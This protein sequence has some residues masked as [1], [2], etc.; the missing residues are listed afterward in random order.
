MKPLMLTLKGFRGIRDGLGLDILTLDFERLADGAELIAIAGANGRGKTT[1]MDNLTP[2]LTLPSRAAAGPGGFSY[3]DHVVLPESEKDLIWAHE[4]RSYRSQVV[5]RLNGRRRTEAFLHIL[6]NTGSWQPMRLADGT[7]SDGRVETYTRCVETVLGNAETFFTSVFSAQGRRHLSAYKNAEI[8]TL[9]ADLL[10][11]EQIRTL[12]AKASETAKLLKAGLTTVRQERTGLQSEADQ[13]THEIGQFGDTRQRIDAAQTQKTAC[14]STVD[15]AKEALGKAMMTQKIAR[16]IE[17][18]RIELQG[19]KRSIIDGEKAVLA[20][21]V[22]LDQRE[23]DRLE[24]LDRR[25]AQRA[26]ERVAK[27]KVLTQQ[28]DK[29]GEVLNSGRRIERAASRLPLAEEIVFAREASVLSMRRDA[30]KSNRLA[31]DETLTREKMAGIEQEAGQAALKA[32][33]LARRLGLTDEVPCTGTD[34]QG[35]CKLLDDARDAK[36]LMPSA[37][38]HVARLVAQHHELVA[39]LAELRVQAAHLHG[40]QERVEIAEKKWRRSQARASA[41]A[42][43]ATRRGELHQAREAFATVDAQLKEWADANSGEAEEEKA[44]RTVIFHARQ[45]IAIQYTEQSQRH[46]EALARID[47]AIAALP[48]PFDDSQITQAQQAVVQA[49][50][51]AAEAESAFMTAVCDHQRAEEASRRRDAIT[52]KRDQAD[53]RSVHIEQALGVW[54]LFAKCMSNDGVIALSIDDAGPTLARLAN[55]LLLACYGP[56]FTVSIKTQVKT[57]KGEARE[58]FDI[59]VHDA[60]SGVSKSITLMSGGERVWINECLIRAIALYLAQNSGRRY[61]TLFSDEADGPLDPARKRMFMAMKREVLRIGGYAQEYF[62]SQTPEL[63]AM[64]DAVIDL[65]QFMLKCHP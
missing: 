48:A 41:L 64:A 11:L 60:N 16:Q 63:T 9:L 52:Q 2:F 15:V 43:L 18:R 24:L 8:K 36:S 35:Q 32:Q 5:I 12:G 19:E 46:R 31:A 13:I 51:A 59:V 62:V 17:A 54:T 50:R 61:D 27:Q 42:L 65:E 28:R 7:V 29:L 39:Y 3:Y 6:D 33:E 57:G 20:S 47:T 34:L 44:E 37:A 40:A 30:D 25:I 38:L 14:Q 58:G 22:Q 23:A 26:S 56:R 10:G 4:G 53:A 49:Q 21:M 1:I 45:Q 55:D